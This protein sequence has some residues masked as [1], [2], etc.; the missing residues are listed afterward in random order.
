MKLNV[1]G[2]LIALFSYAIIGLFHPI[3]VKCQ[4]YF[5]DRVWP[6]FL[7]AGLLFLAVSLFVQNGAS[8]LLSI[9]GAACLWSIR[10]LREQTERVN[11]GWFPKNPKSK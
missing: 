11:K 6:I 3:V 9:I 2:I 4:Y 10:E 7:V 8:I 5:T 1:I